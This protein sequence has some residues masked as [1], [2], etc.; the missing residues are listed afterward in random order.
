MEGEDAGGGT[1]LAGAGRS[2]CGLWP[3]VIA[4]A[5]RKHP[6][7]V[8]SLFCIQGRNGA[9]P[10]WRGELGVT[11]LKRSLAWLCNRCDKAEPLFGPEPLAQLSA[12]HAPFPSLVAPL[13]ALGRH[14]ILL[15]RAGGMQSS[16]SSSKEVGCRALYVPLAFREG[17][18]V[19]SLGLV[20]CPWGR[21]RAAEEGEGRVG[22]W[23]L[24]CVLPAAR[25]WGSRS[26][27]E[28]LGLGASRDLPRQL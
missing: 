6:P 1:H 8:S 9:G 7:A 19:C 5:S 25:G 12:H 17:W 24:P 10:G 4:M 23:P 26:P 3:A 16:C 20:L 28:P 13:V 15:G 14:P 18:G 11:Q 27:P 22:P 21:P 2:W